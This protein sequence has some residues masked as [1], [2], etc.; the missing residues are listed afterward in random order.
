MITIWSGKWI[1]IMYKRDDHDWFMGTD[2]EYTGYS[3]R[4]KYRD[5]L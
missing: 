5:I 1:D 3:K 4:N 2:L